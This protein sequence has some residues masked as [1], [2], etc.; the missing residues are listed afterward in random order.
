MTDY[1][2]KFTNTGK[3]PIL[4]SQ[5]SEQSLGTDI[6]LFGRSFLEYGE[7]LNENL[8][9]LLEN[10][11]CP[12]MLVGGRSFPDTVEANETLSEPVEGQ[13]WYNK[14]RGSL[15][16]FNGT[17]WD[18]LSSAS[19][20]AANWGQIVDGQ[21]LPLPL[22]PDGYSFPLSECIWIVSP[23]GHAGRFDYMACTTDANAV[24]TMRYRLLG[25][26]T[27]TSG[28]ANY[29]II[30]I[31]G[32][33]RVGSYDVLPPGVTPTPTPTAGSSPTPTP[34]AS[35][36]VSPSP[37]ITASPTRTPTP[38]PTRAASPTPTPVPSPTPSPRPALTVQLVDSARGGA[39]TESLSLCDIADYFVSRDYGMIGCSTNFGMCGTS[40]CAPEPGTYVGGGEAV[41]PEL[42]ITCSGGVAPYT[43]RFKNFTATSGLTEFNQS[44]DCIFVGG[45]TGFSLL[46]SGTVYTIVVNSNGGSVNGIGINA[47]CGSGRYTLNGN[48][49]V[50]VTDAIGAVSTS[51]F[52]YTIKRYNR[53]DP[54]NFGFEQD[55]AYW[56]P[57]GTGTAG[58]GVSTGATSSF[59]TVS[60]REGVK[61]GAY[62]P[63]IA[64]SENGTLFSDNLF[65]VVQ[66]SVK[67]VTAR[68]TGLGAS[69][70][71]GRVA[72]QWLNASNGQIS[73]S[74]GSDIISSNGTWGTSSIVAAAPAG[75]TKCRVI[76]RAYSQA[77][78]G[79]QNGIVFFD[80]VTIADGGT[81]SGTTG[82]GGGSNIGDGGG[83]D[84]NINTEL[85]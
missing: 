84:G 59:G 65:T 8:L 55:L 29:L 74:E 22:T 80:D 66:G 12:E 57:T 56:T 47:S 13:L 44:G 34:A 7:Q 45:S 6:T 36:N 15:Y 42:G 83:G 85:Q 49:T 2:V 60:P 18:K 73:I 76:L 28:V 63:T 67:T 35:P 27:L 51:T 4:V 81:V 16:Q 19:D 5:D 26:S 43:V 1:N 53:E 25:T 61:M 30:G 24:V 70:K 78:S 77:V 41:G 82:G 9:R 52:P 40:E 3:T 75:A 33:Q 58:W 48:F 31:K 11:A 62:Y 64:G 50:E 37:A 68:V 14:T 10:F 54:Q 17:T 23:A 79:S 32:N 71:R 39:Y 46:P 21:Q 69:T 20:Y 38:T 72:I